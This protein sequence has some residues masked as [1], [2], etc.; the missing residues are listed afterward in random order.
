MS[1][2][3]T[4]QLPA[5]GPTRSPFLRDDDHGCAEG[6]LTALPMIFGLHDHSSTVMVLNGPA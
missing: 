2:G 4:D 1:A 5:T 6:A 3:G